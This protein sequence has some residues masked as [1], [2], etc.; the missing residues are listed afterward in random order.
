M[1][2]SFLN[3][4]PKIFFA[5][6]LFENGVKVELLDKFYAEQGGKQAVG[7]DLK[8]NQ[9]TDELIDYLKKN[10]VK[11]IQLLRSPIETFMHD[12]LR[13]LDRG[14]STAGIADYHKHHKFVVE[15]RQRVLSSFNDILE[16][17]YEDLTRGREISMLPDVI[18]TLLLN[19]MGFMEPFHF[20][21]SGH[22]VT[23]E[24]TKIN[25]GKF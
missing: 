14:E 20:S 19:F 10:E 18:E 12:Q 2:R 22:G 9:I 6:E 7:F 21:L 4:H 17:R 8:Y 13:R 23:E 15:M 24:Y 1:L 5:G 3:S 16:L 11:V 25:Y